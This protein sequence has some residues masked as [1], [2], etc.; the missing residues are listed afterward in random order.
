MNPQSDF[1]FLSLSLLIKKKKK[2]TTNQMGLGPSPTPSPHSSSSP[3]KSFSYKEVTFLEVGI[4]F[5]YMCGTEKP[6]WAGMWVGRTQDQE[7]KPA[8]TGRVSTCIN[9]HPELSIANCS[10][11]SWLADHHCGSP[12]LVSDLKT[13]PFFMLT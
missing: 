6:L 5:G 8:G 10:P 2:P 4:L 1:F 12:H 7:M 13:S 3:N 11:R 9:I